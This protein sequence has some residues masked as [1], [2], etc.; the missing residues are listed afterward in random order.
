MGER[1]YHEGCLAAHALDLIGDRWALLIVRELML[2]ARRFADLRAGLPGVSANILTRRLEELEAAGVVRRAARLAPARGLDYA[3]TARGLDLWPV[4]RE[5]CRWAGP[6]AAHDPSLFISPAAL[7][8]SMRAMCDRGRA[9]H[10]NVGFVLGDEAFTVETAPGH[11]AL[12]RGRPAGAALRFAGAAN[13][14]AV[15]VYGP[16]PLTMAAAGLIGFEGD[17]VEG[18]RFIDL[19]ALGR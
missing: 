8:L 6:S 17:P 2:G 7:M 10:H 19:F 5:L 13:P 14:M 18:Q 12:R 15:A 4:L 3:L 1:S 9:G 16:M 11:Y